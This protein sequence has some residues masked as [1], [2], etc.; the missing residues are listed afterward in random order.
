MFLKFSLEKCSFL[1]IDITLITKNC[2]V[3]V[4]KVV[5]SRTNP[6]KV[7]LSMNLILSE[8]EVISLTDYKKPKA[9][10]RQLQRMGIAFELGRT[11]KP[12]VLRDAVS[13]RLGGGNN[14]STSKIN[15]QALSRLISK[16]GVT[17]GT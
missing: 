1:L 13:R 15:T 14:R 7:K 10:C 4:F 2:F 11:G 8:D 9:Q 6:S 17:D 3:D 12:K 16:Q 5:S